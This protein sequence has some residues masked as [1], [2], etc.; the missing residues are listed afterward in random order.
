MSEQISLTCVIP[1]ELAG[2][3]LD[4]A[5][6][7][8]MPE[9]SRSRLCAWCRQ[10][11]VRVDNK[12]GKPRDKVKGGENVTLQATVESTLTW[13]A[14]RLPLDIV[15][16][17]DALIVINK[18]AGLVVH[19]AAGSPDSTLVNALLNHCPSLELLPR[20]GLIHRLDKDTTGLLVV[21]KTLPAHTFLVKQLQARKFTREYE[22]IVHGVMVAGGTVNAPMGRHPKIRVKMAVLHQGKPAVTHYRVIQRFRAHTHIK[23][24]LETGRTHQIRVHL[25][26]IHYPVVGDPVYGGRL[27][28]AKQTG[29]VLQDMLT[30]FKRQALHAK[31][32]GLCHPVTREAIEWTVPVPDDMQALLK[33]LD[34]DVNEHSA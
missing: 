22:A 26:S 27:K 33:A 25:A 17:D 1:E 32:L 20:A 9:Y 3:R 21:A 14:Q 4:Q 2:L 28:M 31:H 12:I 11:C 16:E 30:Q 24:A 23:V 29:P 8:L 18:P 6:A 10:D 19:P 34:N 7:K 5:L 15:Y 13:K